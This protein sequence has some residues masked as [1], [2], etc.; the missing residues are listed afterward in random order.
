MVLGGETRFCR[1]VNLELGL[2]FEL[3]WEL[4]LELELELGLALE[5]EIGC[6]RKPGT[7][8]FTFVLRGCVRRHWECTRLLWELS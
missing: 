6:C 8:L 2:E 7:G 1:A 4:E 3:E 5:F